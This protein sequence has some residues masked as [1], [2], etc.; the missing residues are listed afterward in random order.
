MKP[1]EL[2]LVLI[3][4]LACSGNSEI[5]AQT[6]TKNLDELFNSEQTPAYL[7]GN[8]LVGENG[9]IIYRKS[10]GHADLLTKAPNTNDST[11]QT[12]SISKVFTSTAILQ[13]RDK[14][15]LKLTDAVVKFLPDFPYPN[16]T[17]QNLLSHTSGLPNLELYEP[18]V[19]A[20]P[21][22][23]IANKD[24]IPAL[25]THNKPLK[26]Q[27]GEKWNYSNSNY[28][29]LALIVEKAGNLSFPEY[30][31][32]FIFQPAGMR[33][34]YVRVAGSQTADRELVKNHTLPV[35][36][37]T[38]PQDVET[39]KLKDG[40]R[41]WRIR[42]ET[43]NLGATFGDQN[44][45]ST[46]EDLFKFDQ[47]LYSEKLL[48]FST[49]E[50]AFT[51]TRLNGGEVFIDDFGIPFG[52]KCSYGLGWIVCDDPRFGKIV[53]HDGFNRGIASI[54]YRNVT[55]K[56]TV[57]MFDNTAGRGFNGK[58]ASVVNILNGEK[59]LPLNLKNSIAR[60]FGETLLND[61]IE[62]AI[63]RFNEL[64]K[65]PALYY[66]DEKE[67]NLLG[68]DFLFNDYKPQSLEAFKLNALLF[69][70]SFNV[71]DSYGES[72]AA[73]GRKAEAILMYKKAIALNP[74]SEGSRKALKLLE[75]K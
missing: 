28:V 38:I 51:P 11:F 73:T 34:T 12:A 49:I 70:E 33:G 41:M 9:K 71:Y 65:D 20:N 67:M 15:K 58:A 24:I 14:G 29:L 57:I 68:Y 1:H 18:A 23:V 46:V 40:V 59:P 13:L 69:P 26:F 47:A 27:P 30:L 37:Q 42:Y 8:V 72:L 63:L 61:G 35:M 53:G 66:L 75:D 48:K 3:I 16:I 54:F 32:K 21:E 55:K 60:E 4:A 56:Q 74:N 44:V 17:I 52:K 25:K 50:E 45:I 39:V 6:V 43:Y 5:F 10:F 2:M 7:N 19:K 36:Y 64:R 62:A 22:L 31:K